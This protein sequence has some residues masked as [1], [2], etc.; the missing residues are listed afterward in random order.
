VQDLKKYE[1]G[2]FPKLKKEAETKIAETQE[3]ST[4]KTK[5]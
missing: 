4:C 3:T 5:K 1:D 2:D